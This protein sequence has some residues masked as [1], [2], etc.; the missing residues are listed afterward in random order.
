MLLGNLFKSAPL[1]AP[2]SEN[3][4]ADEIQTLHGTGIQNEKMV[5]IIRIVFEPTGL[6]WV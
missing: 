6:G 2:A 3:G 5:N 4:V 1:P